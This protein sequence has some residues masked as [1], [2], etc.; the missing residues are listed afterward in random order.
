MM[1]NM[2]LPA[3]KMTFS[4]QWLMFVVHHYLV[5]KWSG[6]YAPG[7]NCYCDLRSIK[8]VILTVISLSVKEKL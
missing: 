2:G 1:E 7:D 5:V 8:K 4:N 6:G 3:N